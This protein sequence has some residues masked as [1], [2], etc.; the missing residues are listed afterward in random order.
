MHNPESPSKITGDPRSTVFSKSANPLDL[1]HK[2]T[3]RALF[4][5]KSVDPKT[6][7]PPSIKISN[8]FPEKKKTNNKYFTPVTEKNENTRISA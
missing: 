5:T 3:I 7:S 2:S 8:H 1:P 6:Y 4:K